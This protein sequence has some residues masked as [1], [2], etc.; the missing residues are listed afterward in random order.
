MKIKKVRK[1]SLLFVIGMVFLLVGVTSKAHAAEDE[2]PV[3]YSARTYNSRVVKNSNYQL[4]SKPP[5]QEG[6]KAVG[7]PVKLRNKLVQM[8]Q[9][10]VTKTGR[11]FKI[12]RKSHVYGWLN[13]KALIKPKKY[14]LPYTYTSQLYPLYAPNACEAASLKMALSVKGIACHTKLKT[15]IARMP[16]NANPNKG[17]DGNPYKESPNNVI[18]TIYPKPL[19]AY[20]K[21]YDKNAAN[22]TGASKAKLITEIKHGNAVVTAGSWH[23]QNGRPYHVLALVGYK[24]GK[25]LVADP[26]M[27]K[28]WSGKT[29]WVSTAQ[30][31]HVFSDK[32]RRRR[33][34]VIR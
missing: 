24:R 6:A 3:I 21:K 26:Y 5:F 10:V 34:V 19:T 13:S 29:F 16:R 1:Y 32:M 33:A 25:F 20:A 15:I 2:I 23:Y 9:V 7:K 22:I 17:F 14:I 30:F 31:M 18:W 27:K 8:D 11:Y 28:S 4:W 12:S